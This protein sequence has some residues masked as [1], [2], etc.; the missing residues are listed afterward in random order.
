VTDFSSSR[1]L[2]QLTQFQSSHC[3][4][5][6]YFDEVEIGKRNSGGPIYMRIVNLLNRTSTD[7]YFLLSYLPKGVSMRKVL[8]QVV[9]DLALLHNQKGIA[10]KTMYCIDNI[11]FYRDFLSFYTRWKSKNTTPCSCNRG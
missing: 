3:L 4:V 7:N 1:F 5:H 10:K 9:G 6:I 11:R 8:K 2:K